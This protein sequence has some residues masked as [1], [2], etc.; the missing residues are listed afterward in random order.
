MKLPKNGCDNMWTAPILNRRAAAQWCAQSFAARSR[1]FSAEPGLSQ[2]GS[3][4]HLLLEVR[5]GNLARYIRIKD[6]KPNNPKFFVLEY[7]L[8]TKPNLSKSSTRLSQISQQLSKPEKSR[9][10]SKGSMVGILQVL[11]LEFQPIFQLLACFNWWRDQ[12]IIDVKPQ[13]KLFERVWTML[14]F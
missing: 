8:L 2:P 12:S 4:T 13:N 1:G 3:P 9:L 6:M 5:S 14:I 7:N 10:A 11:L